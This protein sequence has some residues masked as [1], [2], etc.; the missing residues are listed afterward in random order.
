MNL[1]FLHE[2]KQWYVF[3]SQVKQAY[4]SDKPYITL[5]NDTLSKDETDA[6]LSRWGHRNIKNE[7]IIPYFKHFKHL[8]GFNAD[9]VP[10][11]CYYPLIVRKLNPTTTYEAFASKALM[12][13]IFQH[14]N[15]PQTP[16]TKI[17]GIW[18]DKDYN[19]VSVQQCLAL[20]SKINDQTEL[21]VKQSVNS[22]GG[23]NIL[24]IPIGTTYNELSQIIKKSSDAVIQEVVK[25]SDFTKSF[26]PTSLNTLRIS[27]LNLNGSISVINACLKIGAS[28][29]RVDNGSMGAKM[30]GISNSGQ[31]S[32]FECTSA[33]RAAISIKQTKKTLPNYNIIKNFAVEAHRRIP[34][35]GIVGWDIALDETSQPLLIEANLWW[36][37]VLVPQLAG[38]PFFSD[39]TEEIIAL[40]NSLK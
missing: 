29:C 17:N 38:G 39:R 9:F 25:Q 19:A 5:Y 30:I 35:L 16:L 7:Y 33:K 40:Y 13:L 15:Q 20:L 2:L 10:G 24:F 34:H 26:N 4:T 12:P 23:K 21:I 28:G 37:G 32:T 8:C 6:V 1:L 36:P 3:Q 31:L 22:C 27:T 18:Y 14:M 11:A